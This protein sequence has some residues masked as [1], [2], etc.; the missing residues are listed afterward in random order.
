MKVETA[1]YTIWDFSDL[2]VPDG[3]Y[4]TLDKRGELVALT[5]LYVHLL[6]QLDWGLFSI[7]D[8]VEE[9]KMIAGK[10]AE[11]LKVKYKL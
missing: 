5:S 6:D 9:G 1:I 10:I 8:V 7:D 4:A 3:I 2:I 11:R